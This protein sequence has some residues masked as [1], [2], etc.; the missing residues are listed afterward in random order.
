MSVVNMFAI[1]IFHGKSDE[2]MS[3]ECGSVKGI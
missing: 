3:Q 2:A 1:D